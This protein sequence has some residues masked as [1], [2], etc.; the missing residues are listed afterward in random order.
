MIGKL[1]RMRTALTKVDPIFQRAV[2]DN[3]AEV[4]DANTAQLEVGKDSF[5]R[6][7]DRYAS[8]EYARFKQF[9]GSKAPMG[10]ADLKLEGDFYSG[11]VIV[12][13]GADL[14]ITSTDEKK[15]KL[16]DKYGEAIFG[17]AEDQMGELKSLLL[18]SFLTI[19]R[20]ELL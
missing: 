12:R 10:I 19:L 20:N 17:I 8:D 14:I 16:R 13:K 4:L 11:F 2:L 9:W 18:E 3:E 6:L 1:Q 5:G 15:D 7:L